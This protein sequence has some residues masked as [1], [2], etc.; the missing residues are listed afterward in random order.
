MRLAPLVTL[1]LF[2]ASPAASQTYAGAAV[3]VA[4]TTMTYT[5]SL[6]ET[7]SISRQSREGVIAGFSFAFHVSRSLDIDPELIYVHKG[8]DE[9]S[10]NRANGVQNAERTNLGYVELPVLA[11]FPIVH[12][13]LAASLVIGPSLALRTSCS[14]ADGYPG[15]PMFGSNCDGSG[16]SLIDHFDWSGVFGVRFD[17]GRLSASVREEIGVPNVASSM[18]QGAI[19]GTTVRNRALEFM[20]GIRC[21]R[22]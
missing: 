7:Q 16:S 6:L 18:W 5:S 22:H 14:F 11:D 10:V 8:Y 3:G 12:R 21:R 1:V 4:V 2:V 20:I 13:A 15:G 17:Y 19:P 9:V